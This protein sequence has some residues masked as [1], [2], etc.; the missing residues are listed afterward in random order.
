MIWLILFIVFNCVNCI[1]MSSL[2]Y[3]TNTWQYWV[4]IVCVCG[5]YIAGR[6]YEGSR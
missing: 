1:M 4:G 5:S 6:F 2:G 3:S